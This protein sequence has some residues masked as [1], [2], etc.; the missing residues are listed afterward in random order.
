MT[1]APSYSGQTA[2]QVSVLPLAG[3]PMFRTGDDLAALIGDAMVHTGLTPRDGDVVVVAQ[4]VVSKVEGRQ[5]ALDTVTPSPEALALATQTGKPASVCHLILSEASEV[6]RVRE[7]LVI[8]RHRLG[9]V[10]ASAGIDASNV[11]D[12]NGPAQVLLWPVDPDASARELRDA[13]SARFGADL[14]VIVSDSLGRA[15]A[16]GHDGRGHR[17]GRHPA[18]AGPTG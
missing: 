4:K 17:H 1:E 2:R 5:V 14:A 13:L 9:Q 11:A 15:L 6:M 10:M 3:L 16:D 18:A 8:V 12:P 7:N